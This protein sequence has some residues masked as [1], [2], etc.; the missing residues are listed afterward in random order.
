[1]AIRTVIPE[2]S[3]ARPEV[4]AA[5]ARESVC[6][7]RRSSRSR[8][9]RTASINADRHSHQQHDGAGGIGRMED[10]ARDRRQPAGRQ[11]GRERQQN[12]KPGGHERPERDQQ[13]DERDRQRQLLGLRD[14][15]VD[16]LVQLAVRARVAELGDGETAVA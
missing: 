1:M 16:A 10:V 15:V 4:A 2:T 12:R 7:A 8:S 13:H 9:G 14:A 6:P 11:H 3:T 5:R